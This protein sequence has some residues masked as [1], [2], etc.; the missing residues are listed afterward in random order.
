MRNRVYA[1]LAPPLVR[2]L[3]PPPDRPADEPRDG[4][5]A[6]RPLLPRLR[7]DLLLPARLHD[8]RRRDRR[9]P[10]LVE[11]RADRD[12][13]RAGADRGRVPLQPRRRTRCC[14]TCS[15]RW[16]TSRRSPRRTSSAST[17]SSRSRRRTPSRRSSSGARKQVFALTRAGEPAARV[18][19]PAAQLPAAPRAGG[20]PARRR[21]HGRERVAVDRE[22][23]RASTSS[24]RC[25]SC[26][27]ARSACG[28]ARRS[29]R[30][31]RASASSR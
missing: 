20:D 18:L 8:R 5:P 24:S 26:R 9:L 11:A 19:H 31:R 1:K 4:R 14:A 25:S 12:G 29:A 23:R 22:L 13:D 17:S 10:D 28:S 3:R 15:R 27:C 2:L 6:G 16:P 7:P 30:P 21:P